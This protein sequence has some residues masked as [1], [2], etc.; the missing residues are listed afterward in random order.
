M[1]VFFC[2]GCN[3]YI[4]SDYDG[5]HVIVNTELCDNCESSHHEEEFMESM[6]QFRKIAKM[7]TL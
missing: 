1:S 2:D 3:Q 4:D 7:G 6:D 5:Y